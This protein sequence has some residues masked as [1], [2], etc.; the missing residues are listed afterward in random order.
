MYNVFDREAPSV[1]RSA[2]EKKNKMKSPRTNNF[3]TTRT[4]WVS[5][6]GWLLLLWGKGEGGEKLPGPIE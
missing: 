3:G 4:K 6:T 2:R 5:F 1:D